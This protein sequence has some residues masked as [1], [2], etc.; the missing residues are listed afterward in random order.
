MTFI[1]GLD[2][3][4]IFASENAQAEG[5]FWQFKISHGRY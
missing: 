5:I 3:K 4:I 2:T 1:K